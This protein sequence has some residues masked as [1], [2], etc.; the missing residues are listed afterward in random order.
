LINPGLLTEISQ[1]HITAECDIIGN[2][3]ER[4]FGVKELTL[5]DLG[6]N[7]GTR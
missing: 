1:H 2:G 7:F 5:T 4:K 6:R 3:S